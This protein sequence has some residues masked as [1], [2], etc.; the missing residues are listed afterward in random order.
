MT[1]KYKITPSLLKTIKRL[2]KLNYCTIEDEYWQGVKDFE[3][4]LAKETDIKDIEVV[5]L[6]GGVIGIGNTSRTMPL[7]QRN[8]IEK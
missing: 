8:E 4:L 2:W 1:K 5:I 3:K 7:L 6:E